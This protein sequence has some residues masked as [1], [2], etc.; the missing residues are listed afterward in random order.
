MITVYEASVGGLLY[1]GVTRATLAH[2]KGQHE[3]KVSQYPERPL[4]AC[5]LRFGKQ[6]VTWRTL[7]QATDMV[8]ARELEAALI[9]K[10]KVAGVS[11][12]TADGHT[13]EGVKFNENQKQKVSAGTAKWLADNPHMPAQISRS[14]GGT[15]IEVFKG[16][17]LVGEFETQHAASRSLGV[18]VGNINHCLRGKLRSAG[19]YRYRR[20]GEKFPAY[21]VRSSK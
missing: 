17:L 11:L 12:N 3:G 4:Y 14:L 6:A 8:T 10:H 16:E 19:G 15:P 7:A 2:R 5:I 1:I 20:K 9:A 18:P 13:N 21:T